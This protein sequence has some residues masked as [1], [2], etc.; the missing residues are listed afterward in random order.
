M[1]ALATQAAY[2][3]FLERLRSAPERILML[4]YDGTLAPFVPD[5]HLAVPY[6]GIMPLVARIMSSGTRVVLISGRK[7]RELADLIGLQPSPEIWGS[8]GMERLTPDGRYSLAPEAGS[9]DAAFAAAVKSL[10]GKV[11]KE[12]EERLEI[13]PGS[14]AVHWR[15]LDP[16]RAG[17]L[18][19]D[20]SHLWLPLLAQYGLE[21]HEFDGGLELRVPG[22]D[23]G[24]A[25]RTIL[26]EAGPDAALAYLGD[27]R[28]DEDAFRALGHAGLTV[29]VR[30][31][32]RPTAAELWLQPPNE[33]IH[34]LEEWLHACGG[35]A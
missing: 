4:D 14:I 24:Q 3:P 2:S 18:K 12:A 20:V 21:L 23:K 19:E 34:F 13:K 11:D 22:H 28:T 29:L 7:A 31:E 33:L 17:K 1:K 8:H 10:Q 35:E 15:G 9:R 5:R 25:V 30:P 26:A 32:P 6:P 16:A 27:D